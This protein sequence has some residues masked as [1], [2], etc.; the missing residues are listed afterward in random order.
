MKLPSF[1]ALDFPFIQM[2]SVDVKDMYPSIDNNLG[3]EALRYYL[4]RYPNLL[5]SRFSRESILEGMKHVLE[6][7]TGYFNGEYY[8]QVVGT[9]TGIKPAPLMQI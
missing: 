4:E 7:N 8:K 2:W 5:P 1:S 6:N 9:A 3:L